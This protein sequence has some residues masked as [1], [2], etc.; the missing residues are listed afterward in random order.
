MRHGSVAGR[1]RNAA[2]AL[3]ATG[4]IACSPIVRNHGYIPVAEDLNRIVI[5]QDTRESVAEIV[6]PPTAGGVLNGTGY[7]YV[8]SRFETLGLFRPEEVSREVLAITF[9][10]NGT[11]RNIERFGLERGRVVVLSRRVTDDNIADVSFI[12][13]LLGNVGRVN[14]ADLLGDG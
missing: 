4:L 9:N 3:A 10:A 6:G 7:Y 14:A 1:I 11:V 5:G 2:I 12:G 13:Q 8:Q